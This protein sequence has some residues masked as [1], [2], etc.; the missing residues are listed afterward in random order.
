MLSAE[1]IKAH[2]CSDLKNVSINVVEKTDSTNS[3]VKKVGNKEKEWYTLVALSQT[4]GRGRLGKSFFSPCNTG[5]YFSIL[6][7]PEIEIEDFVMITTGAAVAVTR[8]L[9]KN[10]VVEPKI[11]WVNDIFIDDKKVCGILAE[12]V[13]NSESRK[14]EYAVLGIGI[15]LTEPESGFPEELRSIAGAALKNSAPDIKERFISE[16]MNEFYEIY[17][18]P[19]RRGFMAEYREKCFVLGREIEVITADGTRKGKAISIDEKAHLQVAFADGSTEF[20]SSGEIS[21]KI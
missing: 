1:K 10:G 2:L 4:A 8:A 7:K 15:N 20:I 21:I 14:I 11:K 13:I 12:S 17:K 6:L 16:F 9:E 18:N 5:V 19:D 3:V